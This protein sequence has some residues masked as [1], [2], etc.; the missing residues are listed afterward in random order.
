MAGSS[1][2]F[3]Y[4][5]IG[6]MLRSPWMEAHMLERANRMKDRAEA[7]A[8]VYKG[9]GTDKHRGRY[10]ASFRTHSVRDGGW[11]HDRAAGILI[12]DAPEAVFVEFGT[13]HQRAHG[14]MREAMLSGAL[15]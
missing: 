1:M 5:G 8:P 11:R 15:G 3:S 7:I 14:T 9:A 4:E 6:E 12:N 2:R 13:S 10:K